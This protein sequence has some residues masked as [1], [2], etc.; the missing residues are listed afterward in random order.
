MAE[1]DKEDRQIFRVD[2][3]DLG[4]SLI[5]HPDTTKDALFHG[6]RAVAVIIRSI[7]EGEVDA[8]K[9]WERLPDVI[10]ELKE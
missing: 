4:E 8:R 6:L 10:E 1:P 5:N 2:L 7:R 9:L 3:R